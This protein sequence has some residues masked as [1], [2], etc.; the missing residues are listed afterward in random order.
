MT[1]ASPDNV[2]TP[3]RHPAILEGAIAGSITPAG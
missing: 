3:L 2:R 1:F